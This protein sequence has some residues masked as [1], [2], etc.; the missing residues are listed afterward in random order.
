MR[1]VLADDAVLFREGVARIL[2]EAGIEVVGQ[3]GDGAAVMAMAAQCSPDAVLV[4]IRMPPTH[5][6]EGLDAA[7]SIREAHP[8]MAVLVLSQYVETRHAVELFGGRRG[9]IGYLLKERVTDISYLGA[10]LQRL[11]T[12][13][14][15]LDPEVVSVLLG[16][17][18]QR[19]ELE[20]LT[21][22]ELDVLALMAEGRSNKAICQ[23]LCLAP[24]T[25]ETHVR[26]I[27]QRLGLL[28]AP[29]DHRRVLAVLT[30]LGR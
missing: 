10:T 13:E 14:C 17:P 15:V 19:H 25:V 7:M 8:G 9:G 22:R 24:K 3:V 27:F 4:D 5:T 20:A 30:Y 21:P 18:D 1:V 11:C 12:G 26:S 16:A 6:S 23:A 2:T 29:D 28:S